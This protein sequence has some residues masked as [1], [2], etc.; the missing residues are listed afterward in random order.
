MIL[1]DLRH[2]LTRDDAQLVLRLVTHGSDDELRE[3][4]VALRDEGIDAL[5]DDERLPQALLDRRQGMHASLALVSYVLVRHA[6]L[7]A[8]EKDRAIADYVACIFMHF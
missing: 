6:L 3:A 7:R 5:L 1:A 8:G 2:R 4:E